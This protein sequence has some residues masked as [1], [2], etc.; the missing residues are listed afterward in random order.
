MDFLMAVISKDVANDKFGIKKGDFHTAH[1][2]NETPCCMQTGFF[3]KLN[4]CLCFA[5]ANGYMFFCNL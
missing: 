4:V 3:A 2:L 5:D 1:P